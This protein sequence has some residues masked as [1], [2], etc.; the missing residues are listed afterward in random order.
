MQYCTFCGDGGNTVAC[1][2]VS[3]SRVV[4]IA[5]ALHE[6]GCILKDSME[7]GS[8]GN[9][10]CPLCLHKADLPMPVSP[11]SIAN[12]SLYSIFWPPSSMSYWAGTISLRGSS[13]CSTHS[14]FCP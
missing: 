5:E 12:T 3:C 8:V 6:H 10:K 2:T 4:C 9:F 7:E 13:K 1:T 11:S 14:F